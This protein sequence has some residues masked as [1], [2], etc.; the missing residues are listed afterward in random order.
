MYMEEAVS[1]GPE[2]PDEEEGWGRRGVT[3]GFSF[4][5]SSNR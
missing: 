4:W 3:C 2:S 5:V 1:Q